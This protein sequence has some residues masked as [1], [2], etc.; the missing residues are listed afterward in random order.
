MLLV[1]ILLPGNVILPYGCAYRSAGVL[2]KELAR[3]Q[4]LA[5]EARVDSS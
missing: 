4:G 3:A 1:V 2:M 5:Q